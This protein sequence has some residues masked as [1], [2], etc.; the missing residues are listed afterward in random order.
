MARKLINLSAYSQKELESKD[1]DE[2]KKIFADIE[3]KLTIT[4]H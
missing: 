3:K 2:L 4:Y 1:V